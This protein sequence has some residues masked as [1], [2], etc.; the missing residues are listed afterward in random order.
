MDGLYD[1]MLAP[2]ADLYI[3]EIQGEVETALSASPSSFLG[4]WY[5]DEFSYLF[6]AT[7]EDDYVNGVASSIGTSSVTRHEMKY[8][9]WQTGLPTP[10]IAVGRVRFVPADHP[11]PPAGAILMD[12]SVVFGDGTHPTTL[13]CLR[14]LDETVQIK[15]P[16]SMLDLGSGTGILS[17]AAAALGVQRVL[18]V[19]KNRLAVSTT[20]H[21]VEV[22]SFDSRIEIR[23]G[24]ARLFIEE[25]FDLVAAN[26]PFGVL[27]DLV[28]GR[29]TALHKTW[30]VS[31]I[32][33][34]QAQ[35]LK[36]LF[37]EQGFRCTTE[38]VDLPWVTFV[39]TQEKDNR[40]QP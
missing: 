31:G 18:A 36:E 34:G 38:Y 25:A 17:L 9:D 37:S 13:A 12:P 32:N 40:G 24:E 23:E 26:L 20:R 1:R 19:D 7:P 4:L 27:R 14:C 22:N 2:D 15:R 10:G 33:A 5:E 21:H 6:F 11:S 28:P 30:I 39:V 35:V 3:Y 16:R 8:R 29:Y